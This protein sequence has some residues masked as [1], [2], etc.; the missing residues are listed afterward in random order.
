MKE[1]I[2]KPLRLAA[3]LALGTALTACAS[4][5][6]TPPVTYVG[7]PTA[8]SAALTNGYD[9]YGPVPTRAGYVPDRVAPASRVQFAG[10]DG[11]RRAHMVYDDYTA[12]RLDGQCESV[13]RLSYGDTLS[14]IAEY[15]DTTV[16]AL[17]AANP[18]IY[19]VRRLDVGQRIVVPNV[20]G[21]VYEGTRLAATPRT[22]LRQPA[23]LLRNRPVTPVPR[24][25]DRVAPTRS[26]QPV[27]TNRVVT[28]P[29]A[30]QNAP[31]VIYINPSATQQVGTTQGSAVIAIDTDDRIAPI[32]RTTRTVTPG[33]H[34]DRVDDLRPTYTIR[35]RLPEN[36]GA[37]DDLGTACMSDD[38]PGD[39]PRIFEA[40]LSASGPA[41][42]EGRPVRLYKPARL[43]R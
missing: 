9:R 17:M 3:T 10:Y 6:Y 21:T 4:D 11:S 25:A 32:T 43:S 40:S 20:R 2:S 1:H 42:L 13:V 38:V 18:T 33:A 15:C 35:A 39:E 19:D 28:A 37:Y 26:L 31:V 36:E 14:D 29:A 8:S 16:R 12:E 23:P 5:R 27:P 41:C 34:L 22:V 7:T 30:A 24:V